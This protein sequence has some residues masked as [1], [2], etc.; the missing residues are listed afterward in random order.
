MVVLPGAGHE[1]AYAV[2]VSTDGALVAGGHA[3]GDMA[4]W[5]TDAR[6][7]MDPSFGSN[8][9]V[10][11]LRPGTFDAVAS[12]MLLPD[13]RILL[14]GTVGSDV[15]LARLTAGGSLDPSFGSGGWVVHDLGGEEGVRAAV[16]SD[17]GAIVLAGSRGGDSLV[18]RLT[19]D[20]AA[21]TTF[22]G[23]GWRFVDV[24]GVDVAHDVTLDTTDRV[25]V[26]GGAGAQ[27]YVLRLTAAGLLDGGFGAAGRVVTSLRGGPAAA[28]GV[29][30]DATGRVV[31]VGQ[32]LDQAAI[33]AFTDTGAP[34]PGFRD[35]NE[36]RSESLGTQ[37]WGL[38]IAPDGT[39]AA[40][41]WAERPDAPGS[42][43]ALVARY[44]STGY[45]N[46]YEGRAQFSLER[47]ERP[48]DM[49]IDAQGRIV[50]VASIR[51]HW[52]D[53][54]SFDIGVARLLPDGRPDPS[55]GG[56]GKVVLDYGPLADQGDRAGAVVVDHQGRIV[57]V[58]AAAE[59]I[60]VVRLNPE[61]GLDP[62]FGADGWVRIVRGGT[63]QSMASDVA[64]A[65]GGDLIVAAH[66]GVLRLDP[67][68]AL[69]TSWGDGGSAS[70]PPG[71][72]GPAAL[73]LLPSGYVVVAGN[74]C[75]C[76]ARLTSTGLIDGSFGA[77]GM[78]RAAHEE[79]PTSTDEVVVRPD[80]RILMAGVSYPGGHEWAIGQ[81]TADG[82][83]DGTFG[84]GGMTGAQSV[85]QGADGNMS[86]TALALLDDGRLVVAGEDS[87]NWTFAR[88]LPDGR[89]DLS[90]GDGGRSQVYF[91]DGQEL[92]PA[93][94][95]AADGAIIG[96]AG[97]SSGGKQHAVVLRLSPRWPPPRSGYWMLAAD[98][99]VSAFGEARYMHWPDWPS[100]AQDLEPT[101]W[102]NG[103]W[104]VDANGFVLDYGDAPRLDPDL[105]E[106]LRAGERVTAI[107]GTPSGYGYWLFTSL[108][109]VAAFGDAEHFGDMSGVELNGPVLDAIATPSGRGYYMVASDG[110]IFTFGDA[111]FSGSMGGQPLNAP[112][113]SLVPDG[114]GHGYWLVASDGGIFSFDAPFY[115]SMGDTPLNAPV[116]GMVASGSAGYLMVAEDGGVFTFGTA[117]FHGSAAGRPWWVPPIISV[118][119]MPK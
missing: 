89:F 88:Y 92:V 71:L 93:V 86:A 51:H 27:A 23:T 14:V 65:P 59:H 73:A 54:T 95:I 11:L 69:R 42:G 84:R 64:V 113:Q 70:L 78:G 119:V 117:Q 90:F 118:A 63:T 41:G 37:A 53:S 9:I 100:E 32:S 19:A 112:V 104:T 66:P 22:N 24:G 46:G 74:A 107:S 103:Y 49:V 87:W 56:D 12:V 81:L 67:T 114:D 105:Y 111:T 62:T 20:G 43:E 80:G 72:G 26:A 33:A 35:G 45:F 48:V 109:R 61:G 55:F 10:R 82:H 106:R 6:G 3:D 98:G 116:R 94:A 77:D 16:R 40:A 21:D 68:G 75:L 25:V 85:T 2:A 108:G 91:G 34:A 58:G 97:A 17:A 28:N 99:H 29:V 110:G 38:A 30:V 5:R 7:V 102:G 36:L 96:L 4:V 13:G 57:V 115:G 50:T 83:A 15:G 101:P 31:I 39:F 1:A 60:G 52:T 76:A 44:T 8:G 18:G 79:S 47:N